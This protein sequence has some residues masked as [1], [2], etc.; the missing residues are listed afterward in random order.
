MKINDL[1]DCVDVMRNGIRELLNEGDDNSRSL[2]FA[3]LLDY[4][5]DEI[6]LGK[7]AVWF[8]MIVTTEAYGNPIPYEGFGSSEERMGILRAD[9]DKGNPKS[10]LTLGLT[11]FDNDVDESEKWLLKA[12]QSNID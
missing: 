2:I 10:Q 6:S 3:K 11:L 1:I 8:A 4:I 5:T 12:S 9:A 7:T